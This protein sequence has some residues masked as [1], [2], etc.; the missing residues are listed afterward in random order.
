MGT[1]NSGN[2]EKKRYDRIAPLFDLM[3]FLPEK[4]AMMRWR[5]Q[6]VSR[7][8]EGVT[9]ELGVGTGKNLPHYPPGHPFVAVDISRRMIETAR[10]KMPAEP[11]VRLAVMNAE[12]LSFPDQ[13]FD[14]GVVTF[15]FC[16]VAHPVKGLRE[17]RRVLKPDGQVL[18]I[19]HVLP[20]SASLKFLF[21]LLN[22]VVVRLFGANI[23]RQTVENIA[24]AGFTI[25]DE[26][27]LWGDVVKLIIA[28]P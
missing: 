26:I 12:T 27:N 19:E 7:L 18:F 10:K 17:L 15:V 23:N 24:R 2:P 6:W 5:K 1:T 3:E 13:V 9:L 28:R 11:H 8:K 14:N 16:S 25:Q 4:M 22:P 21:N 20:G